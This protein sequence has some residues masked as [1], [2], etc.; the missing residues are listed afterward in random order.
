M[1]YERLN[2][3]GA[4]DIPE[5]RGR[6]PGTIRIKK[7]RG[8]SAIPPGPMSPLPGPAFGNAAGDSNT[9]TTPR[10]QADAGITLA[11]FS[12]SSVLPASLIECGR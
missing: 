9:L 3:F 4:S 2:F 12:G 5:F 11:G 8:R 7:A 1:I 10:M 6:R